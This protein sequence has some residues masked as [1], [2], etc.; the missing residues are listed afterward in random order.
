MASIIILI[1]LA[2]GYA[3]C[4][5]TSGI[6]AIGKIIGYGAL[7]LGVMA[8]IAYVPWLIIIVVVIAII[9]IC[10]SSKTN[11]HHDNINNQNR[12]TNDTQNEII[13]D[14][15]LTGFKAELQENTKTPQQVQKEQNNKD[16]ELAIKQAENDYSSIKQNI[17]KQAQSGNY[18]I[19]NGKRDI[20][21]DFDYIFIPDF[22]KSDS[23]QA[24]IN[25]TIFNQNG[26]LATEIS[27]TISNH[28]TYN[29]YI[30]KI[31]QLAQADG[32]IIN[33]LIVNKNNPSIV[34]TLPFR[35]VGFAESTYHYKFVLRCKI[36]Y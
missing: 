1:I 16:I 24:Y 18:K 30:T 25:K 19:I 10:I 3:L 35:T 31:K 29:S 32:I 13:H 36:Q 26:Q 20:V 33:P 27:F 11:S 15:S 6:E 8:I 12:P 17:L 9:W 21:Y 2:I 4:G 22:I 5:D 14:N 23:K 34:H 28:I 7:I